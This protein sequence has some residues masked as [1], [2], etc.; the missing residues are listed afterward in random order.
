MFCYPIRLDSAP[1]I[2]Q[3]MKLICTA[4]GKHDTLCGTVWWT[5]KVSSDSISGFDKNLLL[6]ASCKATRESVGNQ[7]MPW[8]NCTNKHAILGISCTHIHLSDSLPDVAHMT[9]FSSRSKFA[10]SRLFSKWH[11]IWG[12]GLSCSKLTMLLRIIKTLIIKCGIYT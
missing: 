1:D 12:P 9:P 4:P 10:K 11:S 8:L 6:L 7:Q 2:L 5:V 3:Q